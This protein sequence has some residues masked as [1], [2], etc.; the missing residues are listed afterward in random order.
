MQWGTPKNARPSTREV[1]RIAERLASGPRRA[2]DLAHCSEGELALRWMLAR[3]DVHRTPA[4][5]L[6]LAD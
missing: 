1:A 4:G 2:A 6:R 5:L 3:G